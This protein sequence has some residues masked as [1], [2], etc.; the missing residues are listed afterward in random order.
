METKIAKKS[1]F[2]KEGFLYIDGVLCALHD[3]TE[4]DRSKLNL[5]HLA[6]RAAERRIQREQEEKRSAI[7]ERK[8][9]L[10]VG[11]GMFMI[12]LV[13]LIIQLTK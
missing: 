1:Y 11:Y 6:A 4:I 10:L 7:R 2:D 13:V 8:I 12:V 9:N 5:S 3:R